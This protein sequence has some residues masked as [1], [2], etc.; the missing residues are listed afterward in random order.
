MAE[1]IGL[2]ARAVSAFSPTARVIFPGGG[3]TAIEI[4]A[5]ALKKWIYVDPYLDI[6]LE[7]HGAVDIDQSDVA[8]MVVYAVPSKYRT[9]FGD[10]VTLAELFKYRSYF[11]HCDRLQKATMLQLGRF[12]AIYGT[13]W[14]LNSTKKPPLAEIFPGK[15][16][17]HARGRYVVATSKRRTYLG[18]SP[19]TWALDKTVR[20]SAWAHCSAVYDPVQ[21]LRNERR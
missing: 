16:T 6:F 13:T 4:Y 14:K 18:T 8:G 2:R 7:A 15:L 5:S 20:A 10:G 17:L 1:T 19:D 21:L 12:E 11:D 9:L 3:H